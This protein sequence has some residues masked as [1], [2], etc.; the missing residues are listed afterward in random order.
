M[1]LN[2]LTPSPTRSR[3]YAATLAA[4]CAVLLFA[5][6]GAGCAPGTPLGP[7][8][9]VSENPQTALAD[10]KAKE[11]AA[12]KAKADG[13]KTEA[14]K[15]FTETA[16]YYTVA[17]SRYKETATG[18]EASIEAARI[19]ADELDQKQQAYQLLKKTVK[20]YPVG[21]LGKSSELPQTATALYDR[22]V[23]DLDAQNAKTTWYA[24]MDALMKLANN[25]AVLC[26]FAIA[27]AVTL[28]TWPLRKAALVHANEM[29]RYQPEMKKIQDKYK[30]EPMLAHEKMQEFNKKH[31][32]N[33]FAG[34]L[35]LLAQWPIT[36]LMYQVIAHYQFH[37]TK[38]FFLWINPANGAASQDWAFPFKGAIAPNLAEAD[39]ALMV[40]YA[41]SMYFQTRFSPQMSADPAQ[42]EQ[43][44]QMAIF[45]PLMLFF[46]MWQG[47][48]ASAFILYWLM[49]NV[50]TLAQQWIIYRQLPEV[51]PLILDE[52]GNVVGAENAPKPVNTPLTPNPRLISPKNRKK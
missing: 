30:D 17:A 34:C 19:T 25:N 23:Y 31:G 43:A 36:I 28:A 29:K 47:Q 2:R 6:F 8:V 16:T 27:L 35:P 39:L 33:Q 12:L 21:S 41:V 49:S 22:V 14:T 18:L 51:K 1:P 40:A 10:G 4:L 24:V 11:T 48:W 46:F 37:F 7:Q 50:L 5:F 32:V 52:K 26:L 42:I 38:H 44:K 13:S 15:L 3:S 20:E 45:S 9:P